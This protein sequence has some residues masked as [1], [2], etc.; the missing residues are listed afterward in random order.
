MLLK[1]FDTFE[2]KDLCECKPHETPST[3]LSSVN[4]TL[5]YGEK[6]RCSEMENLTCFFMNVCTCFMIGFIFF[7]NVLLTLFSKS[8]FLLTIDDFYI[9]FALSTFSY[10]LK[11]EWS[12]IW[13]DIFIKASNINSLFIRAKTTVSRGQCGTV[14]IGVANLNGYCSCRCLCWQI[15]G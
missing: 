3:R 4:A 15:C 6:N 7:I 13:S 14:V 11:G 1:S 8:I 12:S 5:D 10:D 9:P 2:Q